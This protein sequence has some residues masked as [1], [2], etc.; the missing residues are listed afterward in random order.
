MAEE[1]KIV[2][3]GFRATLALLISMIALILSIITFERTGT[4][5]ELKDE[6][7]DLLEILPMVV[8][9]ATYKD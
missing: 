6:I 5:T 4:Q 7:E 1:K 8:E 2:K 3:G 9:G